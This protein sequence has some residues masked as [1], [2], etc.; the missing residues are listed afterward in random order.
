MKGNVRA[1]SCPATQLQSLAPKYRRE[2]HE[3]MN[4]GQTTPY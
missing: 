4:M 2:K 3:G 1:C